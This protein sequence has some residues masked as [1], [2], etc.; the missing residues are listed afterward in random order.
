[1]N[2]ETPKERQKRLQRERQQQKRQSDKENMVPPQHCGAKM[3]LGKR[4]NK[5]T[6]SPV[7]SI[8]CAKGKVKLPSL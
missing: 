7:F 4:T 5:S 1:M 2:N 3:W 6:R 8:C